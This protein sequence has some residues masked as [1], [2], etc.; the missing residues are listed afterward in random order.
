MHVDTH[1]QVCAKLLPQ[2]L[3]VSAIG[4]AT[5]I[6]GTG[7]A[8]LPFAIGAAAQV[9]GVQVFNPFIISLLGTTTIIWLLLPGIKK[10]R[11]A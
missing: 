2:H 3:H 11:E 10:T 1:L 7:A 8:I 6:G 5:A 9:N 4:L